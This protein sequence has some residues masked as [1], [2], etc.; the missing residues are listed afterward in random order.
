MRI[1][2]PL[3]TC[4]ILLLAGFWLLFL[5]SAHAPRLSGDE[6]IMPVL[7]L[8][9][10]WSLNAVI[11]YLGPLD[12]WLLSPL[13][14]I[15]N[16]V[17]GPGHAWSSATLRVVPWIFWLVALAAVF[18]EVR[19]QRPA[20]GWVLLALGSFWPWCAVNARTGY[21]H[22]LTLG[23]QGLIAAEVLRTL[24]TQNV[25]WPVLAILVGAAIE[26]HPTSVV[27]SA[28][29]LLILLPEIVA[30]LSRKTQNAKKIVTVV[31]SLLLLAAL[32]YPVLR[33]LPYPTRMEY[34]APT[35]LGQ[36]FQAWLD[37]FSGRRAF[38]AHLPSDPLHA[39]TATAFGATLLLLIAAAW[40]RGGD[41]TQVLRRGFPVWVLATGFLGW[42]C[43]QGRPLVMT[44][45]DRYR[46]VLA[47]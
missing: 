18:W 36:E 29:A 17:L 43:W 16:N 19:R 27:A 47:P 40:L 45:N 39:T 42:K 41:S 15:L 11:G 28:A 1:A 9:D 20:A 38:D 30:D 35:S 23:I 12:S 22:A 24:R 7:W 32:L 37:V 13:A 25:R 3:K 26:I 6:A 14:V 5:G 34:P 4:F 31:G 2:I 33:S 21:G 8:A 46:L 10:P 44:G